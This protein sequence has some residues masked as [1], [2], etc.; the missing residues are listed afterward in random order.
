[1]LE[2]G[3]KLSGEAVAWLPLGNF[4]ADE[5]ARRGGRREGLAASPPARCTA[6]T[7][8]PTCW[9][10]AETSRVPSSSSA[11]APPPVTSSP[12]TPSR[13]RARLIRVG[14][15]TR[16][17]PVTGIGYCARV[18][19]L[20]TSPTSRRAG[21]SDAA[22]H[23]DDAPLRDDIRLLGRVLGEVIGEQAGPDVLDMVE[24]TASKLSRSAGPRW[25]VRS[26]RSNWPGSTS[27]RPTTSSAPSVT[28]RC[29]PTWPRTSTTSGAASSTAA[30]ARHRRRAASPPRSSCST[31]PIC[32]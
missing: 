26:S 16:H 1:M 11:S 22:D 20:S 9:P 23:A 5:D 4:R 14:T 29:W 18:R 17:E 32:R 3:A 10:S 12:P 19:S 25:T 30:R 28:S 21:S 2:R 15:L 6:T 31:R 13:A 24:S 27:G 8:W 7:T